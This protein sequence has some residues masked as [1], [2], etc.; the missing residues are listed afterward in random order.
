M[1]TL[2]RKIL[3]VLV[4]FLIA[5]FYSTPLISQ[6]TIGMGAAPSKTGLLQLKDQESDEDNITSTTGGF[7]LPRVALK[8][9]YTLE[10]FVDPADN[11]YQNYKRESVGTMVYNVVVLPPDIVPGIY[12]WD[13]ERWVNVISTN[14]TE[15]DPPQTPDDGLYN[16]NIDDPLNLTL[17][18]S[19]LLQQGHPL[20]IPV[21]KGYATWKQV[22]DPEES[23]LVGKLTTKLLWQSKQNLIKSVEL[24]GGDKG[25][26]SKVKIE[27]YDVDGNAVVGILINGVVKW[28]WHI[29]ITNYDPEEEGAYRE[30]N[31]V[32]FMDRNLGALYTGKNNILTGGMNYQWGRKDPFPG[33]SS[34]E[35]NDVERKLYD[36]ENNEVSLEKI[37]APSGDNRPNSVEN[38][39][40]YYTANGNWANSNINFWDR[41]GEKGIVDPCPRGWRVPKNRSVWS[42]L[43]E[44]LKYRAVEEGGLNWDKDGYDNGFYPS[45]GFREAT[46][47]NSKISGKVGYYWTSEITD[48][49]TNAYCLF[50]GVH[51]I[52]LRDRRALKAQANS[53]RC[54]KE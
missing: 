40:T 25:K 49:S 27:T 12:F 20:I 21:M 30:H 33:T 24:Y 50:F 54:V 11:E 38:P 17:P 8:D 44:D 1:R 48:N 26:D 45:A 37:A 4:Y 5:I 6:V 3:F 19:Y 15:P 53:V 39:M 16:S 23:D 14:V 42:G 41:G 22:L 29:W 36:I 2:T 31:G 51:E 18:N 9:I 52:N 7:I 46:S 34:L 28:S 35:V 43:S 13:G 32:T 47:G 10:P